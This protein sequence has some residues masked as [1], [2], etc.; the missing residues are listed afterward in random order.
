MDGGIFDTWLAKG[1]GR[2]KYMEVSFAG[3]RS[4]DLISYKVVT[5]VKHSHA[6]ANDGSYVLFDTYPNPFNPQ[7]TLTYHV[8]KTSYVSLKIIDLLGREIANLVSDQKRPGDYQ[9]IWN[10]EVMS[11]GIYFAVFR[12]NDFSMIKKLVLQK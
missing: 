10:P 3:L 9:I 12:A 6:N 4:Y 1:V 7:T 8:D 2:V 11:S 5:T